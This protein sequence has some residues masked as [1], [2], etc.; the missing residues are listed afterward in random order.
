MVDRMY[1][2]IFEE[3][4]QEEHNVSANFVEDEYATSPIVIEYYKKLVE[5]HNN[6]D[7]SELKGR[8]STSRLSKNAGPRKKTTKRRTK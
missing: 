8:R 3:M 2:N 5:K 4:T 7:P 1:S 6:M